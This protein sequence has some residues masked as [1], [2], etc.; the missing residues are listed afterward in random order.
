MKNFSK[1]LVAGALSVSMLSSCH[2]YKKF[3]M[4][5]EDPVTAEYARVAA[6]TPDSTAYG[7][8]QW[9]QVFTDPLLQDFIS[10]ALANNVNLENARLNIDIARA[11]LLGAK[12]SYLPSVALNPNGA[13]AK[14]N[15]PGSSMTWTYTIPMAASW[16]IDVF[17]KIL[18]NKRAAEVNVELQSDY[19]QAVRSQI[20]GGVASCYYSIAII[21]SQLDL[22]RQ[23]SEIWAKSV[24]TMRDFKEAGRVTEAAVVQ[25][26]AQYYSILASIT[27]LETA[28]RQANNSMS[29]LLNEQ[30]QVYA[31][32]AGAR[33][34]VPAILRDGIA[35]RE[36]AQRPDV[37]RAEKSLAAAYYNTNLAR[38]AFY[39]GLT[40]SAQG[41]FTNLLGSFIKNPGDWF[42]QL[43][44]QLT[45]PLFARGQNIARLKGAKVQQ[46]QSLN[47]FKYT[48]LN[49][50]AEIDNAL[51]SLANN[52]TKAEMLAKQEESLQK[53]VEY[54][55]LLMAHDQ[56]TTYLEVLNAQSSLLQAQMGRLS[57]ELNRETDLI[58]L[59]QALGGG[60]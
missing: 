59:Y 55:N 6:E 13:G 39:P 36:I 40:I 47:N 18:N 34:D 60:R 21:E 10:R 51:V 22:S 9:Q 5:Q 54:T 41:G 30:P 56:N 43:A 15:L 4:P 38:A 24:Q 35:L 27:D 50:A 28:L 45:A 19:A 33:L 3:E 1:L 58:T 2:I 16:E 11:N 31:I 17:G 42:I 26:E 53:A 52:S 57:T 46:E 12:L 20:I 49:A 23:T 44:G 8:L 37:R 7:N 32:P 29:L 14:Y 48:L 25:S